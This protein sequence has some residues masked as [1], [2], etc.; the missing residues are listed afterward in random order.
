MKKKNILLIIGNGFDLELGLESSYKSFI[1]SKIYERYEKEIQKK[2]SFKTNYD[3]ERD[4]D[5]NIF[6]YFKSVLRIQNWIDLEMEIGKLATRKT[7]ALDPNS[8]R[9]INV[10][11]KSSEAMMD[12]FN[13]LRECLNE[14]IS[15]LDIPKNKTN[16]AYELL[17]II[18]TEHRDNIQIV[19]FNYTPIDRVTGIDIKVPIYHIH[20]KIS[21]GYGT[22]IILGVQDDIEV[23]KSYSYIIKSHSPYY[24]SSRIIDML[25]EAD[26]VI[27]F[28]H[29]LGETDYPYFAEFFQSQCRRI[30]L[31]KRK[32]IRIFTF[33]ENSRLDI[34]YQ[35]RIMNNKQTRT[36]FENSDFALYRT[37]D[38]M[39]DHEINKYFSELIRDLSV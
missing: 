14:Y 17:N 12:S 27:F 4:S 6:S 39:D 37:F 16:Y 26:E 10:L 20:G 36:F 1:N 15:F 32:K 24:H 23:D 21:Q 13:A 35:L 30:E 2:Y 18:A 9:R 11:M 33:D 31:E 38:K 34:L 7:I 3:L 19:T 8:E 28:G 25:E 5:L 29:S 22:K